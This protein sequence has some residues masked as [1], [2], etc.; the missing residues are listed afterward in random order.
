MTYRIV[1]VKLEV[2]ARHGARIVVLKHPLLEWLV[3]EVERWEG[4][5][6]IS[7]ADTQCYKMNS[8]LFRHHEIPEYQ[9]FI[10]CRHALSTIHICC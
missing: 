1:G 4:K 7:P 2:T 3:E 8:S 9:F 5:F 6:K 10:E